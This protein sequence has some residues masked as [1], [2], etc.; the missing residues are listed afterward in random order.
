MLNL[1][2]GRVMVFGTYDVFHPGHRYFIEKAQEFG[3]ELVLVVARDET[4]KKIK[5]LLRNSES[6]RKAVLE[7]EFPDI[8]VVLGDLEDPMRVVREYSPEMVCLGY[9]QIG[10]SE[11]LMKEFPEIRV[12][13]IEA[14]HPEKYKS[15]KMV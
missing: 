3:D 13:R 14:F 4:V 15:S 2:P 8:Q 1:V 11:R 6:L 7:Q 9:D 5:P 12:E 10:F